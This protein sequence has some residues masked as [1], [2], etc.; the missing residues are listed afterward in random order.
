MLIRQ[1]Y[2]FLLLFLQ[3]VLS[4]AGTCVHQQ[5]TNPQQPH[6]LE[7]ICTTTDPKYDAPCASAGSSGYCHGLQLDPCTR[8]TPNGYDINSGNEPDGVTRSCEHFE[9]GRS[10]VVCCRDT[11]FCQNHAVQCTALKDPNGP[12]VQS[13]CITP[14]PQK[15]Q[16]NQGYEYKDS[17]GRDS[18][19]WV[20]HPVL[21]FGKYQERAQNDTTSS[22]SYAAET[23]DNLD[24]GDQ[25]WRLCKENEINSGTCCKRQSGVNMCEFHDADV[26]VDEYSFCDSQTTCEVV[27]EFQY[28]KVEEKKGDKLENIW[29][30]NFCESEEETQFTSS[31]KHLCSFFYDSS[32]IARCVPK[33][34]RLLMGDNSGR[35]GY[36]VIMLNTSVPAFESEMTTLATTNGFFYELLDLNNLEVNGISI[37]LVNVTNGTFIEPYATCEPGV[38][39]KQCV[40][41]NVALQEDAQMSDWEDCSSNIM[42]GE[43]G[44]GRRLSARAS[45]PTENIASAFSPN[46]FI[47]IVDTGVRPTHKM[48]GG[49]VLDG[50]DVWEGTDREV[51]LEDRVSGHGTHVAGIAA[52]SGYYNQEPVGVSQSSYII[53]VNIFNSDKYGD[54]NEFYNALKWIAEDMKKREGRFVV[55]LSICRPDQGGNDFGQVRRDDLQKY[56]DNIYDNQGIIVS[57]ACNGG[58]PVDRNMFG[59]YPRIVTVGSNPVD[60]SKLSWFSGWDPNVDVHV[61][62]ENIWS[63]GNWD[64]TSLTTQSGTSMATPYISGVFAKLWEIH[65]EK[66]S[67]ELVEYFKTECV[68]TST[69]ASQ[70]NHLWCAKAANECPV[71]ITPARLNVLKE[72]CLSGVIVPC[73]GGMSS[74]TQDEIIDYYQTGNLVV[75]MVGQ[76]ASGGINVVS[77]DLKWR[78]IG[79]TTA[80]INVARIDD[81][82]HPT[83]SP[84]CVGCTRMPSAAPTSAPTATPTEEA[85]NIGIIIGVSVAGFLVVGIL[86]Y[87]NFFMG[88][89][90]PTR[91]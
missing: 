25:G 16:T 32:G 54:L 6:F 80:S 51:G 82:H 52:G 85:S 49:R 81:T 5:L 28:V 66:T 23:C 7:N 12:L 33:E 26:W 89:N 57:A 78:I 50:Y 42:D 2:L 53:P 64:D 30:E 91:K 15:V 55:N 36:W 77:T 70:S 45:Y 21:F 75:E 71:D 47:Y 34:N 17:M 14:G 29:V 88:L 58:E 35:F 13:N 60:G 46:T 11:P 73:P 56:I 59:N 24:G 83:Q 69:V 3:I 10:H 44:S 76:T 87:V 8:N 38:A 48:F 90:D 62:G 61:R 65:P 43:S 68:D 63:A 27:E 4:N 18:R 79:V 86:V 40:F 22:W 84:I 9:T 39:Y 19:V 31:R 67:A 37:L 41:E 20:R 1:M 72:D 74:C